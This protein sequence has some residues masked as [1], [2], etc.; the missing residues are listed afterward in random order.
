MDEDDGGGPTPVVKDEVV[1]KLVNI[2]R[3]ILGLNLFGI[4]LIIENQTDRYLIIDMNI[5]PGLFPNPCPVN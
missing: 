4:D 2:L 3:N 5:F 1:S